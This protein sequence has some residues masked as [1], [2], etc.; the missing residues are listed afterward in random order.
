MPRFRVILISAITQSRLER[1]RSGL[2]NPSDFI[3]IPLERISVSTEN[4]LYCAIPVLAKATSAVVAMLSV[5]HPTYKGVGIFYFR[6]GVRHQPLI[7]A[8][9]GL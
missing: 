2:P 6:W 7:R 3:D 9:P 1:Y 4:K 5:R 8:L